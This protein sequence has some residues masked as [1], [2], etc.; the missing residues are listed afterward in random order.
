MHLR[1]V[2]KASA[3]GRLGWHQLVGFVSASQALSAPTRPAQECSH[4]N[5]AEQTENT[6]AMLSHVLRPGT[7]PPLCLTGQSQAMR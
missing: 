7:S 3:V 1:S 6:Q 5:Q 4:S 2:T